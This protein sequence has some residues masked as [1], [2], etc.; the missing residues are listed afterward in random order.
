[1]RE[2]PRGEFDRLPQDGGLIL[3]QHGGGKQSFLV[4]CEARSAFTSP[5]MR[6]TLLFLY[7]KMNLYIYSKDL[8]L[9][10]S[11]ARDEMESPNK[12]Q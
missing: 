4:G 5:T 3:G 8:D 1:M 12:S 2:K 10:T 6:K 9:L 7:P 11:T